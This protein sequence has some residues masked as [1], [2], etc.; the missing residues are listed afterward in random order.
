MKFDPLIFI[1][2]IFGR[3]L[4]SSGLLY[5]LSIVIMDVPVD[6]RGLS[7]KGRTNYDKFEDQFLLHA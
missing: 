4:H 7:D 2:N 3:E 5:T 6:Y 1:V